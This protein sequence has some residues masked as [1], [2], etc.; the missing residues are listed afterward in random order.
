MDS[1]EW[2]ETSA[3]QGP[4]WL[5]IDQEAERDG[6]NGAAAGEAGRHSSSSLFSRCCI[7]RSCFF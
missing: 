7:A 4:A 2:T 6:S 3:G 1:L 5:R